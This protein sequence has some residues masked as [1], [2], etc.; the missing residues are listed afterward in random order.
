MRLARE[1]QAY[2]RRQ[3]SVSQPGSTGLR[4]GG[5]SSAV[6]RP[7]AADRILA[8]RFAE[9]AWEVIT[10]AG[11]RS[12]V[13]GLRNGAMLLQDF[14]VVVDPGRTESALRFYQLQ[15]DVSKV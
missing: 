3:E 5:I 1:L 4:A 11:E 14:E 15:K 8:A 6:E 7:S 2:F 9:A 13:L 10:S 12:G